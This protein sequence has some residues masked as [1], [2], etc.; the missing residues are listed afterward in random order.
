M[1][2]YARPAPIG[3]SAA[4]LRN[5]MIRSARRIIVEHWPR[6]DR[7]LVCGSGWPCTATGYAYEFLGSV[8]QGDWV[9]PQPE[10]SRR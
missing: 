4:Q 9:P 1:A 3:L 10:G 7:C 5:R 8:G 6:V 2:A